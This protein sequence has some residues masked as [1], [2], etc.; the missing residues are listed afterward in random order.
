M[1]FRVCI[2]KKIVFIKATT[3]N[4]GAN[5]LFIFYSHITN[6]TYALYMKMER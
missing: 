3:E 2:E 4:K 5:W 1:H 6:D